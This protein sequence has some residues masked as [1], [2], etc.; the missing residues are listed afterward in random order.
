MCLSVMWSPDEA[1]GCRCST[2]FQ[3]SRMRR[4]ASIGQD[5]RSSSCGHPGQ[6]AFQGR[7]QAAA[8]RM[9][10][11]DGDTLLVFGSLGKKGQ[12]GWDLYSISLAGGAYGD[13]TPL[14]DSINTA[15]MSGMPS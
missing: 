3:Q 4:F 13:P 15:F 5:A 9:A 7:P 6:L 2:G 11:H 1:W 8:G 14:G 12:N 10:F